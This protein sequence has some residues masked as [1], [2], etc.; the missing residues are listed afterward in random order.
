MNRQIWMQ[1]TLCI[2]CIGRMLERLLADNRIEEF[3]VPQDRIL[4]VQWGGDST[5]I[6]CR[7]TLG[8]AMKPS[9]SAVKTLWRLFC[10]YLI[11]LTK[12]EKDVE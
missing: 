4:Y 7:H 11:K 9:R 8:Q 5:T 12:S 6:V 10:I 2:Q 1:I 3:N